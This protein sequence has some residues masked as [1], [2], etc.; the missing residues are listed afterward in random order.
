MW[1]AAFELHSTYT[2]AFSMLGFPYGG[3][4]DAAGLVSWSDRHGF[5][6]VKTL[7]EGLARLERRPFSSPRVLNESAR[8]VELDAE[9]GSVLEVGV[10]ALDI[11][12]AN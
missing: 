7:L 11:A 1:V 4:N 2:D 3:A 8:A 10:M 5:E 12:L 9:G 6:G